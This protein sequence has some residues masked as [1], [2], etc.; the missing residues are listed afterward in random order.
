MGAPGVMVSEF[1]VRIGIHVQTGLADSV[2]L[3]L[4]VVSLVVLA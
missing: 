1:A 3:A 2:W 4:G